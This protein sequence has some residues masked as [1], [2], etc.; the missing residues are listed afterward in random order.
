MADLPSG[1]W[2][3]WI[4]AFTGFSIMGFM[5]LVLSVYFGSDAQK[6][7]PPEKDPVWDTDL[8]EGHASP[9]MWWFW[10]LFGTLIVSLVYLM[11]FPGLGSYGGIF[12]WSQGKRLMTAF[13]DFDASFFEV[14]TEIA[15]MSVAEIQNDRNLMDVAERIFKRECAACHGPEGYGQ[16]NMFPNL[17]DL[18]WQWGGS[19]EQIEAT[20]LNGR[21]ANMI[22]W[23]QVLGDEGVIN[24]ADYVISLSDGVPDSHPGKAQ[25]EQMCAACHGADG[26]GNQALGAPRLSDEI[27]LYG[28]D[29]QSVR[30]TLREGRFGVMPAFGERLDATQIKLLV[31]LLAR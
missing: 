3:G 21:R 31:A 18:D 14:R 1:F 7:P 15:E 16:A 26:A 13:D 29:V 12:N 5:W 8:R 27:W 19:P 10:M 23:Q 11:F 25:F 4:I 2:S 9:P 24:V 17:H 30:Q 28:G 20:L 6:A 22:A